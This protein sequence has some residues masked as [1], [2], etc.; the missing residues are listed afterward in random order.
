MSLM[1]IFDIL[2]MNAIPGILYLLLGTIGILGTLDSEPVAYAYAVFL[3]IGAY[4]IFVGREN[5]PFNHN[6]IC[7][8]FWVGFGAF[9]LIQ[10]Y[11]LGSISWGYLLLLAAP[12]IYYWIY[13]RFLGT[14]VV[15]VPW[16]VFVFVFVAFCIGGMMVTFDE[17]A[18]GRIIETVF[19]IV[20]SSLCGYCALL[21]CVSA[22]PGRLA[23]YMEYY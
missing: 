10:T 19:G 6:L 13:I 7:M 23:D 20:L 17:L 12:V 9:Y 8:L 3:P 4:I 22:T 2:G 14:I 11:M 18:A 15:Y 21:M 16:F 5:S 1:K